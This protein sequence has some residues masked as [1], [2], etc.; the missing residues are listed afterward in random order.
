MLTEGSKSDKLS[1]AFEVFDADDDGL[2]SRREL[3]KF[4][5]AFLSVILEFSDA[6][7]SAGST[8]NLHEAVDD[9]AVG[10]VASIFKDL[11]VEMTAKISF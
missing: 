3:W 9:A 10:M 7:K 4:L 11:G 2:L 8:S 1:L 5:R 6:K